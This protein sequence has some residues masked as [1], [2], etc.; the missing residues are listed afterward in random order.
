[1]KLNR[2]MWGACVAVGLGLG[3]CAS[4]SE[5]APGASDTDTG[6][7]IDDVTGVTPGCRVAFSSVLEA[8]RVRVAKDFAGSKTIHGYNI[9][10]VL[11]RYRADDT[12]AL[13]FAEIVRYDDKGGT[14]KLTDADY[15][16][17]KMQAANEAGVFDG[18][19][20]KATFEWKNDAWK[21]RTAKE[22]FELFGIG[23]TDT[24]PVE[25]HGV[26][27]SW[28]TDQKS[29]IVRSNACT[30][31]TPVLDA[32]RAEVG[33]AMEGSAASKS[34]KF[35]FTI[36]SFQ[37]DDSHA[38]L[39]AKVQKQDKATGAVSDLV[40]A[41]YAGSAL[42]PAVHA[43]VFDGPQVLTALEKKDGTWRILKANVGDQKVDLFQFGSS[44]TLAEFFPG[45]G[46]P[47]AWMK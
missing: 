24:L 36:D 27:A 3:G 17:T 31:R 43:G 26:P 16:G 8:L 38:Y 41:D 25:M 35:I 29:P 18:P 9:G 5:S 2:W 45:A 12:Q 37:M 33:K 32:V 39:A 44:D 30:A 13:V 11:S 42:E 15:V 7:A 46:I 40:D 20:V 34:S 28:V 6:T 23:A 1:M 47:A 4:E 19:F 10:F 22:G 21:T 14:V